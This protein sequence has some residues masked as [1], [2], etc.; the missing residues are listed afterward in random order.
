MTVV[1]VELIAA[2]SDTG[3]KYSLEENTGG[4]VLGPGA[5]VSSNMPPDIKPPPSVARTVMLYCSPAW[6]RPVLAVEKKSISKVAVLT[7]KNNTLPLLTHHI[8]SKSS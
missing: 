4:L 8:S 1:T 2:P 5:T 6:R 7:P 3:A